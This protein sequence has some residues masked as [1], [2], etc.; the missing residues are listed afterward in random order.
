MPLWCPPHRWP[1]PWC[2]C[3]PAQPIN[4]PVSTH[5]PCQSPRAPID[6]SISLNH[7]L[8]LLASTG[9]NASCRR[10]PQPHS[11]QEECCNC[12]QAA[13]NGKFLHVLQTQTTTTT[14]HCLER[15]T[16]TSM[17]SMT[18]VSNWCTKA[19]SSALSSS[20]ARCC[21]PRVQAKMDA[22]GLVDVG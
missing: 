9:N 8:S 21:R 1:D 10:L 5:Y 19:A 6:H 3:Q 16:F 20:L 11:C 12:R 15:G 13:C 2:T 18:A 14:T 4:S 17:V 22:T 7:R